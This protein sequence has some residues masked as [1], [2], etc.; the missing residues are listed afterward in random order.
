MDPLN[1]NNIS[2]PK[3]HAAFT[4]IELLVVVAI[5]AILAAILFPVFAQVREK[6]RQT[7][8]LSNGKQLSLSALQYAQD[9]DETW[10]IVGG[11]NSNTVLA[12]QKSDGTPF[13]GWSLILQPYIKSRQVFLCPDMPHVFQG[14]GGCAAFNGQPITNNYSYNYF[15][16]SDNSYNSGDYGTSR[17]GSYKWDHPR[18]LSEIAQPSNVV[19]FLHS[20]SVPP[21]GFDWGC[22]YMTIETPDF[23]NKIRMRTVHQDGDNIAF[24]DGHSKW[25]QLKD[26]DSGGMLRETYIRA[27]RGMW[28]VPQFEPGNTASALGYPIQDN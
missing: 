15:L 1:N 12:G 4:L 8:C 6:A 14:G 20:N 11:E 16:G 24:A 25:F 17:D 7:Q 3:R 23:I 18:S 26:A 10:P 13:N 21:Y 22:T 9:Y 19:A 2:L 28:T 5:I 27:A